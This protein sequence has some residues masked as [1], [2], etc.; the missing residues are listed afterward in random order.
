MT[1]HTIILNLSLVSLAKSKIKKIVEKLILSAFKLN[2]FEDGKLENLDLR[3]RVEP[4]RVRIKQSFEIFA[5]K[6]SEFYFAKIK[7]LDRANPNLSAKLLYQN[8]STHLLS[9]DLE[10]SEATEPTSSQ[11]SNPFQCKFCDFVAVNKSG[12]ITHLT[13]R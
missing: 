10:E 12:F 6:R 8:R 13:V 3:R 5:E 1:R 7:L 11:H 2:S 9:I 4:K